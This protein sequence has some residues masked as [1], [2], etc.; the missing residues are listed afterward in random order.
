MKEKVC[1][2]APDLHHVTK[3]YQP[4][5]EICKRQWTPKDT[6][7]IILLFLY[8]LLSAPDLET[9]LSNDI[10]TQYQNERPAFEAMPFEFCDMNRF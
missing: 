10:G 5:G 8:S 1:I 2:I 6:A 7:S 3:F 9:P 4:N